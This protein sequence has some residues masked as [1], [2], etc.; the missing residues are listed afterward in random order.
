MFIGDVQC[1]SLLKK[2]IVYQRRCGDKTMQNMIFWRRCKKWFLL[3]SY[4]FWKRIFKQLVSASFCWVYISMD[5][6]V[7]A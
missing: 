5:I 3:R 6:K 4:T 1:I 7:S 2:E